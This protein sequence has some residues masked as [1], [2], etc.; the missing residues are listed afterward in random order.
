MVCIEGA[1]IYQRNIDELCDT[2]MD[3][4]GSD[5][6]VLAETEKYFEENPV[7]P[8]LITAYLLSGD[9]CNSYIRYWSGEYVQNT[10]IDK[11]YEHL[12]RLGYQISDDEK[13]LQD[14]THELFER[15]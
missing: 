9:D 13:K 10:A 15:E 12:E 1:G 5:E 7:K 11:L 6:E 2:T 3:K 4:C 14:G 8:M